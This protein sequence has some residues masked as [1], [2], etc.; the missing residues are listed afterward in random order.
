MNNA[1]SSKNLPSSTIQ[2]TFC[3]VHFCSDTETYRRFSYVH[4]VHFV[5][6]C[7]TEEISS[8]NKTFAHV[9]DVYLS[10]YII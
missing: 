4:Y 3:Q 2:D 8:I 1:D 5:M 10:K 6:C 9:Q 7:F